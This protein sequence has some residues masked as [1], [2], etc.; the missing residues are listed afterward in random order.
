MIAD[1]SGRSGD[2]ADYPS[3]QHQ[4]RIDGQQDQQQ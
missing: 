3:C 2:L 4:S 1:G